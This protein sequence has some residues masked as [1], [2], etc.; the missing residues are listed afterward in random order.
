MCS[1]KHVV[2][3]W[4]CGGIAT[5]SLQRINKG[6]E[7][8]I[9]RGYPQTVRRSYCDECAKIEEDR[10]NSDIR[11][12]IRLK[13][14][15]MLDKALLTL[16]KQDTDMYKYKEAIEAVSDYIQEKPDKFDSSYE[17][18]AAIVLIQNR[19]HCKMQ[20]K[21][22]RYQVDFLLPDL[23]VVLE[24]DGDRHQYN[25][26]K[27]SVRDEFIKKELGGNWDIIRIKTDYLDM[28]AKRLPVAINKVIDRRMIKEAFHS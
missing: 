8:V 9:N 16:E 19:I 26:A 25:R 28:N 21:I 23:F 20:Y 5:T 12:L 6:N 1:E 3:C 15:A 17:V 14:M 2:K 24:I 18:L 13:H 27:D 22:G 10:I 4:T 11:E 7:Y